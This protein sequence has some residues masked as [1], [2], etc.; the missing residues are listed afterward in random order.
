MDAEC[1]LGSVWVC[2]IQAA[3]AR[4]SQWERDLNATSACPFVHLSAAGEPKPGG[5]DWLRRATATCGNSPNP[6]PCW[7]QRAATLFDWA[8]GGG[9]SV[10]V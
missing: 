2:T 10:R 9:T 3:L 1:P 4:A 8:I 7:L 5:G 6:A